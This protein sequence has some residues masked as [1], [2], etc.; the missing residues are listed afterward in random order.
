MI[1]SWGLSDFRALDASGRGKHGSG[2]NNQP[3]VLTF[4]LSVEG[5]LA[6]V[7]VSEY[8]SA[9]GISSV[10]CRRESPEAR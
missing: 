3:N 7:L 5:A 2:D 1:T 6:F 10:V 9:F 8:A 4:P